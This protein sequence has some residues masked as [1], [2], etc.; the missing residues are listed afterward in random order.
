MKEVFTLNSF[1]FHL[2]RIN[3]KA[4]KEKV[5]KELSKMQYTLLTL[6]DSYQ[7]KVTSQLQL[8]PVKPNGQY[9]SST[10]E[11]AIKNLEEEK[12]KLE[13]IKFITETINRLPDLERKV[14][15]KEYMEDP[16][17]FNYEIYNELGI[18]KTYY[19]RLKGRAFYSLALML[20]VEVYVYQEKVKA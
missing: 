5:E 6:S 15:V 3:R 13:F 9:H 14:I 12:G 19:Y 16:Y 17:K 20:K 11:V 1:N 18:S 10:E 2:P 4:T 7:P 8:V